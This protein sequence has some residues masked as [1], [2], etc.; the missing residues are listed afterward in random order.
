M[1]SALATTLLAAVLTRVWLLYW[2]HHWRGVDPV[3][4]L[5][6]S[7]LVAVGLTLVLIWFVR[8]VL[9][10]HGERN[11]WAWVLVVA[12]FGALTSSN[13]ALV[14]AVLVLGL[15]AHRRSRPLMGLAAAAL[16]LAGVQF[17]Y[18]LELTLLAKA[19]VL[20][21]SGALLLGARVP[22]EAARRRLDR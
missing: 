4:R 10:E 17:Y 18:R 9:R 8:R 1:A 6:D 5:G 13:P 16:V 20:V 7:R 15:G 22:V 21:A 2:E 14:A 3:E 12:L 19:G 11:A